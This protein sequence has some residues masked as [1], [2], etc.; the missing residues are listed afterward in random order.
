[1]LSFSNIKHNNIIV[2]YTMHGKSILLCVSY[3]LYT[4]VCAGIFVHHGVWILK[5]AHA[6]RDLSWVKIYNVDQRYEANRI[7]GE[8]YVLLCV[9][10]LFQ[11]SLKLS[12]LLICQMKSLIVNRTSNK[13]IFL[14]KIIYSGNHV[15]NNTARKGPNACFVIVEV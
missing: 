2:S 10:A 6:C 9:H 15:K 7:D 14:M 5:Y 12:E 3:L 8:C 1:M 13:L 11:A 4:I